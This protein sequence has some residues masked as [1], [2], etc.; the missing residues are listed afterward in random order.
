MTEY[1]NPLA[2]ILVT[3]G[4]RGHKVLF[5]YPY[6]RNDD[7][8]DKKSD[9]KKLKPFALKRERHASSKDHDKRDR[10]KPV[11][12][13]FIKNGQFIGFKDQTLANFLSVTTKMCGN[14]FS[15]EIDDVR[16]VGYPMSL[17]H[18]SR[19]ANV[20]SSQSSSA[21]EHFILSVNV[22]FVVR[23]TVPESVVNCYQELAKQI[24]V[25]IAHEEK[26]CQYLTIQAKVSLFFPKLILQLSLSL[27][28]KHTYLYIYMGRLKKS[29]VGF[30]TKK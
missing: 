13:T 10:Q 21:K 5:R 8:S 17:L 4:T 15:V 3:S 11:I 24:T 16:F 23:A 9:G 30:I 1:L 25:A 29:T 2:V 18:L 7:L 19:D 28:I 20:Q 6:P 26:R 27:S 14:K 12:K 22:V